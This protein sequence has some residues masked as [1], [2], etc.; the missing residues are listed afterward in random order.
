MCKK[1]VYCKKK[2][3][4]MYNYCLWIYIY[5]SLNTSRLLQI[6]LF[7]KVILNID[8]IMKT[9]IKMLQGPSRQCDTPMLA[10]YP[11]FTV[12]HNYYNMI[13][14]KVAGK[15]HLFHDKLAP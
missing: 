13:C 15:Q 2:K 12:K 8:F 3:I 10:L 1:F 7:F 6:K 4:T 11:N 9:T 5:H 14:Y